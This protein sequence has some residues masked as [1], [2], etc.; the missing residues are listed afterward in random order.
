VFNE[1]EYTTR[2]ELLG[3]IQLIIEGAIKAEMGIQS[4]EFPNYS[5]LLVIP[6]LFDKSQI[7]ELTRLFFQEM[8]FAKAA[9]LQVSLSP[10]RANF[11]NPFAR[12]LALDYPV[13][14]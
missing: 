12:H 5:V 11:R 10:M 1:I 7:Y 13:P 9:W 14:V 3:D 2:Q 4:K 6:D 8:Q